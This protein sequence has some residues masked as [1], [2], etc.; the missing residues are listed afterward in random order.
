MPLFHTNKPLIVITMGDPSG[1]GPEIIM[2]ALAN[3]SKERFAVF[4]IAGDEAV[5]K[6]A[7]ASFYRKPLA[8]KRISDD[9]VFEEDAINLVDPGPE[10]KSVKPGFPDDEGAKKAVSCLDAAVRIVR[11]AP[12]KEARAMVTAPVSKE[13]IARLCPGFVGHTEYLEKA[14]S[15]RMVTMAMVGKH[16][17]V[18]P[19][20]RHIPL[21][22]VPK[23]LT[24]GLIVDTIA[25]VVENRYLLSGKDNPRIGVA[26]LNPHGGEGGRMGKEEIDIIKPAVE[27]ARSFY[28]SI[29]GPIPADVIFYK[30]FNKEI[31]IVVSMYHDQC[32]AP[33]KMVDFATGV[34]TTLGLGCV[35]TSPD[36]GT[37]FDIAGKGLASSASM[38]EA[39][40][41]AARAVRPK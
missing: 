11:D 19:I 15:A 35:R 39:I 13:R 37:A 28:G 40:R 29:E 6:D 7:A 21:S 41:L 1:I 17:T 23:K 34:N 20:T 3:L 32:L 31:D 22:E 18:I 24:A 2:K 14:F 12:P 30:A 26:A 38:E 36:H 10:L 33:F 25:Q 16:F 5:M 8:V 9:V 27:K 4:V